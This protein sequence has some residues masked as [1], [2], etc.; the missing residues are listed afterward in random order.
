MNIVRKAVSALG[1]IFLAALLIAA[2]A[3]KAVRSAVAAALVQVTNTAA[4][5]VPNQDID[6]PGK[7]TRVFLSCGVQFSTVN[8]C[9][10][11]YTV[12]T[13]ARLIIDQVDGVCSTPVGQTVTRVFLNLTSEGGVGA[14]HD[15]LLPPEGTADGTTFYAFN[16]LSRWVADPGSQIAFAV[17]GTDTTGSSVCNCKLSGHLIAFP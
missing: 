13:N 2:L 12:P 10:L 7:A 16:Q 6:D 4:N 3:P 9:D 5:P 8:F 14:G 11:N 15:V 1:G 17:F